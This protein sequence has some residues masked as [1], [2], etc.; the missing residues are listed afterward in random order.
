MFSQVPASSGE[1]DE[2]Q[3]GSD[4]GRP[5]EAIV[6]SQRARGRPSRTPG[7][8]MQYRVKFRGL[9]SQH[10]VWLTEKVLVERYPAL[11]PR[12]L[13]EFRASDPA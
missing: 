7:P 10:D 6:S 2:P 4:H 3:V 9:D 8:T 12:L 11:A 13:Q 1:A 5:I